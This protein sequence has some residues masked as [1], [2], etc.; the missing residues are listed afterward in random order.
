MSRD[1]GSW[2]L[3]RV[4]NPRVLQ[5]GR[6]LRLLCRTSMDVAGSGALWR[7]LFGMP[8]PLSGPTAAAPSEAM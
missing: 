8:S 2:L 7:Q 5:R 6:E 1:M 3:Q 4:Q